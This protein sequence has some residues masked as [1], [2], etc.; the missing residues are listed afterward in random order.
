MSARRYKLRAGIEFDASRVRL[1][2]LKA[3][4]LEQECDFTVHAGLAAQLVD[5]HEELHDEG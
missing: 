1:R 5:V 2:I 3:E 4:R